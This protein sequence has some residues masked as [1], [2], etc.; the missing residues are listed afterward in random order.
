[1]FECRVRHADLNQ[2][3]GKKC[4]GEHVN[5]GTHQGPTPNHVGL[6]VDTNDAL[7][8]APRDLKGNILLAG[9]QVEYLVLLVRSKQT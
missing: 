8:D 7:V 4:G 3:V 2:N 6:P 9:K 1:M 5:V